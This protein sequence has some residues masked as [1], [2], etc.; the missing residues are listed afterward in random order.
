MKILICK[1]FKVLAKNLEGP[2][3]P[4]Q[5]N[6]RNFYF[7]DLERM[8][9]GSFIFHAVLARTLQDFM[10]LLQ[11]ATSFKMS[12]SCSQHVIHQSLQIDLEW[13]VIT[14]VYINQKKRK[15]VPYDWS[16]RYSRCQLFTTISDH[17][18][19][20]L[21]FYFTFKSVKTL[22]ENQRGATRPSPHP[23]RPSTPSLEDPF[24]WQYA[25]CCLD[26]K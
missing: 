18:M 23:S 2:A 13:Q 6:G 1:I 25:S 22:L 15:S 16:Y 26:I 4:F 20:K 21:I 10:N 3:W 19:S 9:W 7:Q 24:P 5:D 12:T 17:E 14:C 11:L 8:T